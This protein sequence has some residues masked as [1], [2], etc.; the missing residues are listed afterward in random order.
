[1]PFSLSLMVVLDA[2]GHFVRQ[3]K[4]LDVLAKILFRLNSMTPLTMLLECKL[5][6]KLKPV[7]V[8][9][10]PQPYSPRNEP[11]SPVVDV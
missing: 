8:Y 11:I 5:S 2:F 7:L 6:K 1:M 10:L 4:H 9:I 3:D